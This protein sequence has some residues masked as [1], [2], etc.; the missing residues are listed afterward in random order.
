MNIFVDS[1]DTCDQW[2][3][4]SYRLQSET[5]NSASH[6]LHL[7]VAKPFASWIS[8]RMEAPVLAALFPAMALGEPIRVDQPLSATFHYNVRQVMKYFH[9]WYPETLSP[10]EILC[11]GFDRAE[12]TNAHTCGC[13][14]GGV[15]SFYTLLHHRPEHEPVPDYQMTH[16]LF[17]HGFDIPLSH[18]NFYS[19]QADQYDQLLA[20]QQVQLVRAH[21]NIRDVT[22]SYAGW[23][24]THGVAL[25]MMAHFLADGIS[26]YLIPSTNRFSLINPPIGSN[27]ITDPQPGSEALRIIHHGCEASRIEK[28]RAIA[29]WDLA[30]AHLRVC[31]KKIETSLNCGSCPKCQKV[32]LSLWVE[33]KLDAFSC[34]PD[35]F[36][37]SRLPPEIFAEIDHSRYAPEKSYADEL[38]ERIQQVNPAA[39]N[40]LPALRQRK[41]RWFLR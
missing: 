32:M 29:D 23:M 1:E 5:R 25:N 13:F 16:G 41:R 40:A 17:V 38:R 24:T 18:E 28:I 27:P 37:P 8:D 19:Q 10:V 30:Q 33:G 22:K 7:K 31:F 35:H 11:N 34:F 3:G 12:A 4:R 39:L 26:R 20:S 6:T 15:D 21:T 2:V 36:N 9:L 14:S